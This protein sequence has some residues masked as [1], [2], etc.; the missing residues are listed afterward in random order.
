MRLKDK[1][2]RISLHD[3]IK[4]YFSYDKTTH[5]VDE[6]Q[7]CNGAARIDVAAINGALHGYEIKS[8]SDTLI[9]LPNQIQQY[10]KVFDYIYIV[11]AENQINEAYKIIPQWWGIYLVTNYKETAKLHLL[12]NAEKNT[13]INSFALLQFLNKDELIDYA[14]RYN[15]GS[16]SKLRKIQK[17]RLWQIIASKVDNNKI[18][19][20]DL[21]DY[22]RN[23][24]KSREN[25]RTH[26][27]QE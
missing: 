3:E 9:R 11:C 27:L 13:Q 17:Y 5:V 24:I 8:E 1:D 7:I 10:N 26:L 19:L 23:C 16:I 25:G 22:L 4:R 12:R 6:L 21:S 15:I 18:E 2:V 20:S 14:L